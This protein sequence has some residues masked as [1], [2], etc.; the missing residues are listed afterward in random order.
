MDDRNRF[1]DLNAIPCCL[2]AIDD[3]AHVLA[4]NQPF[5]DLLGYSSENIEGKHIDSLLT[6]ATRLIFHSYL[7]Q[8]IRL[9]GHVENVE[10]TLHNID[11]QRIDATLSASRTETEDGAV[12]RCVITRLRERRKLEE[13]LLNVQLAAQHLPGVMFQL[14][15]DAGGLF[16]M[17]FASKTATGDFFGL[18]A[19]ALRTDISAIWDSIV[20]QDL[21][22]VRASLQESAELGH[23]WHAI[24][25]TIV[26]GRIRWLEVRGAPQYRADGSTLWHGY[27]TDIS[28]HY[29]HEQAI[30]D[31]AAAER[32]NQTKS[33]FLA[34]M[35]HELRTPLN[36]ILGFA[37]LLMIELQ[38]ELDDACI[39]QLASIESSGKDLLHLINELLDI[40][41]IEIGNLAIDIQNIALQ[42][43]LRKLARQLGPAASARDVS[44]HLQLTADLYVRA[45]ARRLQQIL[46]NLI[47][48]AVKYNRASG[49]VTLQ[50]AADDTC[51]RIEVT[52]Q[53][54]GLDE[55][56]LASLFQPFNRLGAERSEVEGTGLGLTIARAL[57][58]HMGGSIEVRSV[59]GTGS[60]FVL[61]LP[62]ADSGTTAIL[63]SAATAACPAIPIGIR[64]ILYVEDNPVNVLVMKSI[65]KLR[66]QFELAIA[67]RATEALEIMRDEE[68]Q[69][70]LL[71][72][73]LPDASGSELLAAIR[74]ER[75]WHDIPAIA[76]SADA[77]PDDI[78]RALNDGFDE[79]WT[80]PL[81][82]DRVLRVLDY[83]APAPD[84]SA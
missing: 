16:S 35:S 37:Q 28:E 61:E 81:D 63:E 57:A 65:F 13:Q 84:T 14:L 75:K 31:K 23:A 39:E 2:V 6:P 43:L 22:Q 59:V 66:P 72:M 73:Q 29:A 32:A 44:I 77:M 17:P 74:A 27:V 24:F 4:I 30:I 20:P 47:S 38:D 50:A 82:I 67:T 69:L 48:N 18:D 56:Q 33:E 25:R 3:S 80:K 83:I 15:R 54:G 58:E 11:R 68:P 49:R 79:Y 52:D 53:G 60:C 19:D 40:S 64:R 12:T 71:D 55:Q 41:R 76:I 70:L 36:S 78:R 26:S 10:I 34:R 21:A 62:R 7:V 51:V 5:V 9:D 46:T 42:P 8:K 45:D 1:L